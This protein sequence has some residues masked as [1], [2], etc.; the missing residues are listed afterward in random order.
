[1]RPPTPSAGAASAPA[2]PARPLVPAPARSPD[3]RTRRLQALVV[4]SAVLSGV[5]LLALG[6]LS[7]YGP[8][9]GA[10]YRAGR[11]AFWGALLAL[12]P[13]WWAWA[14]ARRR[15]RVDRPSRRAVGLLVAATTLTGVVHALESEQ[16]GRDIKRATLWARYRR[17]APALERAGR[18]AGARVPSCAALGPPSARPPELAD[19]STEHGLLV[20]GPRYVAWTPD[21]PD[22]LRAGYVLYVYAPGRALTDADPVV[23]RIAESRACYVGSTVARPGGW[24]QLVIAPYLS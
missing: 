7:S 22:G 21:H 14:A 13:G 17:F 24:H 5:A 2:L 10:P 11:A 15:P 12:A 9:A 4:A 6:A 1:M 16:L 23:G 19:C 3:A 18:L 8:A 20:L